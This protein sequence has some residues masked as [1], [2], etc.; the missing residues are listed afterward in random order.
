MINLDM[1][2]S[3]IPWGGENAKPGKALAKEIGCE[4]RAITEGVSR[5]RKRGEI[6]CADSR[7]FFRP[8]S[9]SEIEHFVRSMKSRKR[10]I[11]AAVKSA[12]RLLHEMGGT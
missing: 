11:E 5:L 1:L 10:E 2:Y 8:S 4:Y 12:E 9:I 7:G 3:L 6:I